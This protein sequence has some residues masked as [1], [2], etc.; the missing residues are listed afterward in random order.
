[1]QL[2]CWCLALGSLCL[3]VL[4]SPLDLC[5]RSPV[6]RSLPQG[7]RSPSEI[8][9]DLRASR[10]CPPAAHPGRA[11]PCLIGLPSHLQSWSLAS[12]Q[13]MSNPGSWGPR[14]PPACGCLRQSALGNSGF[15][16][17]PASLQPKPKPKPTRNH[18]RKV[19]SSATSQAA[20]TERADWC[21]S[22]SCP[23]LGKPLPQPP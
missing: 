6:A 10:P 7:R 2:P 17:L 8:A 11:L 1:M 16:S 3:T 20:R 14:C 13:I 9:L 19:R 4:L 22:A 21:I 12:R 15:A 18:T 5:S 23:R